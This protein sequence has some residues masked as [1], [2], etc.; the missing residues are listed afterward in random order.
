MP[1]P[2][3]ADLRLAEVE[4]W[5]AARVLQ[6]VVGVTVVMLPAPASS[7]GGGTSGGARVTTDTGVCQMTAQIGELGGGAAGSMVPRMPPMLSGQRQF[8]TGMT[9]E[10]SRVFLH[11]TILSHLARSR[12]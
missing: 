12:R 7:V 4:E 8:M 5:A 1:L 10:G 9:G 6:S 11:V 2:R 3:Q